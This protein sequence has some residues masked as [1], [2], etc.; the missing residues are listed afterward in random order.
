MSELVSATFGAGDRRLHYVKA[1]EGP[2]VVL[3]HGWPQTHYAWRH[4][5]PLI[6]KN[7]T[8]IAPDMPGF[9]Y[10]SRPHIL[11]D[12]KT[13]ASWIHELVISLGVEHI[14]LVGHDMGGQVAYPYAA[15]WPSEVLSL[16][17]IESSLPA[18]GQEALMDVSQG[19][20]WHFG[21]N[22]AGDIAEALVRGRERLFIQHWM[23]QSSVAVFDPRAASLDALDHYAERLAQPGS[24]RTSFAYYR[25]LPVDR[26]DNRELGMTKLTM[27][28]LAISGD[29][30]FPDGARQTMSHVAENVIGVTLKNCGHYPP[31]ERPEELGDRLIGFFDSSE[32]TTRAT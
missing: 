17:Y 2:V 26:A 28:V 1:G 3:L 8:V 9:G 32:E 24:L 16:T 27:P 22:M 18:F 5:I 7:Y 15:L 31:E 20:S 13:V 11:F 14:H 25:S 23:H 10:S 6:S 29:R 21:F 12:K 30:G 4:V 19:G